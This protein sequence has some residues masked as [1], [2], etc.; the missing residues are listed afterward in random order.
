MCI[1]FRN[2][3]TTT[4]V[5]RAISASTVNSTGGPITGYYTTLW[6]NGTQLDCCFI[7][8]SFSVNNGDTY[9]VA[10]S[11]YAGVVF[12]HWSEGTKTRMYAAV[13]GTNSTL[14]NLTAYYTP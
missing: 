5:T 4:V 12:N 14:V 11:D 6:Q 1:L 3:N 13:I 8:C 10:V 7:Q 2:G 9:S